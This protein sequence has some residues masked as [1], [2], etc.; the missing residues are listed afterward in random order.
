MNT[1]P[2][3]FMDDIDISINSLM[4]LRSNLLPAQLLETGFWWGTGF[5]FSEMGIANLSVDPRLLMRNSESRD[6]GENIE[7]L[8]DP[9]DRIVSEIEEEEEGM[10]EVEELYGLNFYERGE[11]GQG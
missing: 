2:Q 10:S 8:E 7:V 1:S 11:E 9:Y 5:D 6:A 4:S 3:L